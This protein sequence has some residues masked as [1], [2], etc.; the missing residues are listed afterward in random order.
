LVDNGY[1][2]NAITSDHIMTEVRDDSAAQVKDNLS[3]RYLT[4][5]SISHVIDAVFPKSTN[6]IMKNRAIALLCWYIATQGGC[7]TLDEH[8][9]YSVYT[10]QF[11]FHGKIK[12]VEYFTLL[13]FCD[14]SGNSSLLPIDL[15]GLQ[16]EI[17]FSKIL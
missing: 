16:G 12:M 11:N 13:A 14:E 10:Q 9:K 6:Q 7:H 4:Y 1:H 5:S 2:V 8:Y 15:P 17:L 3:V